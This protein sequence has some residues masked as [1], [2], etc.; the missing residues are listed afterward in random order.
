[1]TQLEFDFMDSR[2]RRLARIALAVMRA[3]K[4][5][6]IALNVLLAVLIVV[7]FAVAVA[8]WPDFRVAVIVFLLICAVLF[9]AIKWYEELRQ[10]AERNA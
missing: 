5:S 7:F 8:F 10:W 1:M 4:W 3:L 9:P 2:E 6:F